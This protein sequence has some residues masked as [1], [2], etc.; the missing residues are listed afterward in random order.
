LYPFMYP[1]GWINNPPYP[2][3]DPFPEDGGHD[4]PVTVILNWTGGDP[5]PC[6]TVTYDVYFGV[7][8]PPTKKVANQTYTSYE[9]L[10]LEICTKYYWQIITWDNHGVCAKGPIWSFTTFCVNFP[11]DMPVIDGPSSGKAGETYI[12]SFD[13]DDLEGHDIYYFVDWGDETNTSWLGV[14]ESGEKIYVNHTWS[15]KGTYVIMA[16]AKDVYDAI[17]DWGTL[18]VT[19][20]KNKPFFYNSPL[21]NWLFERFPIIQRLLIALGVNIV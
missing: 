8:Y 13:A 10:Q 16:R 6:D 17:G 9:P 14:Y 21:L 4:V 5:D 11:P 12:Y 2:P 3:S 7:T 20:P 18:E 19:M 1:N 15:E